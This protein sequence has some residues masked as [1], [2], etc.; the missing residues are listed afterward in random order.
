M[1]QAEAGLRAEY[2]R[3]RARATED[4]GT[5]G[6][7]GEE[8]WA[9]L[10]RGW[11][12]HG[13]SVVTKGRILSVDGDASPQVDVLILSPAYPKV[14]RDKKVYLAGGVVAAFECKTTLRKRHIQ[15]ALE[16]AIAIR[17]LADP[18]A[19]RAAHVGTPFRELHSP[20]VYGLLAHSHEWS[21]DTALDHVTQ[22]LA[23]GC[24]DASHPSEILDVTCVAD[25][26]TWRAT[27]MS[28]LGPRNG[29]A[30]ETHPYREH[31]PDGVAIGAVSG[32]YREEL[33]REREGFPI[34]PLAQLCGYLTQ[35][36]AWIDESARPLA[37]YLRVTGTWG[38]SSGEMRPWP[39][40]DVY[41]DEVA[42]R[43]RQ[44]RHDGARRWSEWG[45]T[46]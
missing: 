13:Y 39:L 26:G 32:P 7:E 29:A 45:M 19:P 38:A 3:I 44:G 23:Q 14:L 46:F 16:N 41:S 20:I 22:A 10:L 15:E 31:F 28:Y 40:Q 34:I 43:L 18:D 21:E 11:V 36:I 30:W 6:D 35:R 24:R 37:D 2:V 9:E 33:E 25:L 27:R 4:P 17:Q 12:P 42:A 1:E 5:A 8:N